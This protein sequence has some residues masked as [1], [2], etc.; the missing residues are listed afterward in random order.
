M[1]DLKGKLRV[2]LDEIKQLKGIK[3]V[4]LV[5]RDG[6]PIHSVGRRFSRDELLDISSIVGG[7]I[8]IGYH[9]HP[10][11]LNYILLEGKR[12]NTLI[13]SLYSPV[14]S[15]LTKI[16]QQQGLIDN[17]REFFIII[18][19]QTNTDLEGI[20][21]QTNKN[22]KKIKTRLI[23]SG[24]SF[25]PT[26]TGYEESRKRHIRKRIKKHIHWKT[27]RLTLS[28]SFSENIKK[29]LESL[30]WE[31]S[32][33]PYANV[34]V[35]GEFSV[36]KHS[37]NFAQYDKNL[38]QASIMSY[39][40]FQFAKMCLQILK[41]KRRVI[42]KKRHTH[43]VLLDCNNSVHI[44]YGLDKATFS[45]EISKAS[46]KLD[47]DLINLPIS[48]SLEKIS[49]LIKKVSKAQGHTKLHKSLSIE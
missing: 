41:K 29:E 38:E 39:T 42:L 2:H 26:V 10:D 45:S 14:P 49:V 35:N 12:F 40:L 19:A 22:L 27:E 28:N 7:I 13:A 3:S 18:T 21:F 46:P 34:T 30:L 33:M 37:K 20:L 36:S 32:S 25:K 43:K 44:I 4:M 24:E 31:F 23:T 6:N 5:Q 15:S 17:I 47:L 9:L 16:L 8:K 48:Q 11:D 1:I